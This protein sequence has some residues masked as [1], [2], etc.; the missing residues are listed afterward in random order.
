[1]T[2]HLIGSIRRHMKE[3]TKRSTNR[4]ISSHTDRKTHDTI[5]QPKGLPT[6]LPMNLPTGLP[7]GLLLDEPSRYLDGR[8][9]DIVGTRRRC[10]NNR[11]GNRKAIVEECSG[12]WHIETHRCHCSRFCFRLHKSRPIARRLRLPSNVLSVPN[13]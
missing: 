6:S 1:M 3:S 2:C 11:P 10:R 12:H 8:T 13:K 7:T 9:H 5:Y 4:L